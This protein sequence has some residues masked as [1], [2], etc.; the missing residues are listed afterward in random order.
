MT[1]EDINPDNR[2]WYVEVEIEDY[3]KVPEFDLHFPD[4]LQKFIDDLTNKYYIHIDNW[5]SHI[6]D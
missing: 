1:L 5:N 3:N 6:A 4:V 2:K